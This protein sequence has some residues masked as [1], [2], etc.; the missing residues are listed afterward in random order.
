MEPSSRTA[1][2]AT[3]CARAISSRRSAGAAARPFDGVLRGLIH[4][5]VSVT[6]GMNRRS[7]PRGKR[8]Y[9]FEFPR[10]RLRSGGVVEAVLSAQIAAEREPQS[11][12]D[13]IGS[14]MRLADALRVQRGDMVAFV[15]AGGKTSSSLSPGSR[16]A[17]HGWRVIGTTTTRLAATG[18]KRAVRNRSRRGA[19]PAAIRACLASTASS[20]CANE[21]L[22]R[23][24]IIGLAPET[25]SRL[26]DA[27]N[28]DAL[29]I[30]ADGA[31]AAQRRAPTSRCCRTMCR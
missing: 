21:D 7:R 20:F 27:V 30:E 25:L 12:I 11:L 28:S 31:P 24:K 4:P 16:A 10:S 26:M 14:A 3:S 18:S 23:D 5:S 13:L 9:C 2:L 19:S 8:D 22:K 17:R 15:G 6:T 1:R 29:L